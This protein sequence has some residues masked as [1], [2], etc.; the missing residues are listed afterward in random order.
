[1]DEQLI[2]RRDPRRALGWY[3][4]FQLYIEIKARSELTPFEKALPWSFLWASTP[5]S[6]NGNS[7]P[8]SRYL[9]G[10]VPA[11][12]LMSV[13]RFLLPKASR[14]SSLEYAG[15]SSVSLPIS[16][17]NPCLRCTLC[18]FS[19]GQYFKVGCAVCSKSPSPHPT[20]QLS[21]TQFPHVAVGLLG[22]A[23]H[24]PFRLVDAR[25]FIVSHRSS[26]LIEALI[27]GSIRNNVESAARDRV[28]IR[29]FDHYEPI[30]SSR[31]RRSSS[32]PKAGHEKGLCST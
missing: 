32:D 20:F 17:S 16:P 31:P 21:T 6:H 5:T 10:A 27:Q 11:S 23:R 30:G 14:P 2:D 3:C 22:S 12:A 18:D 1:M 29:Q 8:A 26:M 28:P 9:T 24:T 19:S 25:A 4:K 15:T 7:F 13:Q